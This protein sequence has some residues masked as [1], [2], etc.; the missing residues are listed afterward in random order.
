MQ[1]LSKLAGVLWLSPATGGGNHV[2][3]ILGCRE[4]LRAT[5]NPYKFYE[6][7]AKQP[8]EY[9]NSLALPSTSDSPRPAHR[10]GGFTSGFYHRTLSGWWLSSTG[11][12]PGAGVGA[13]GG[14]CPSTHRPGGSP[15]PFKAMTSCHPLRSPGGRVT[16]DELT[17]PRDLAACEL[18]CHMERAARHLFVLWFHRWLDGKFWKRK[19]LGFKVSSVPT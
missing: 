7:S 18:A 3:W 1:A 16:Q 14:R 11:S 10:E 13:L 8:K 4:L 12:R 15:R 9:K 6:K 17:C 19:D 5:E 2:V